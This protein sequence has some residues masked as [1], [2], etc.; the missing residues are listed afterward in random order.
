V[1]NKKKNACKNSKKMTSFTVE[2][3]FATNVNPV[4][5]VLR[6]CN[7]GSQLILGNQDSA[8]DIKGQLTI[9]S[10]SSAQFILPTEPGLDKEVLTSDGRGNSR[11]AADATS[12]E[13]RAPDNSCSVVCSQD[14]VVTISNRSHAILSSS[15][16]QMETVLNPPNGTRTFAVR[17]DIGV[18]IC[19]YVMPTTI[20]E[21]G[22]TLVA[23]GT[24]TVLW[25]NLLC[26]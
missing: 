4:S 2:H 18:E 24:E 10:G 19:G 25:G 17:D 1:K 11:W 21:R 6:V 13:I 12:F 16:A 26:L 23:T 9:N 22:G 7:G 14:E 3:L 15:A 5:D 20:G 8:V